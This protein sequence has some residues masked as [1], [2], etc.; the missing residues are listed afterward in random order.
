MASQLDGWVYVDD[1]D[2]RI[3]FSDNWGVTRSVEQA[4][5]NTMHAVANLKGATA[6]FEFTGTAVSV[7][8]AVGDVADYGW[9][10][11]SYAIDGKVY[12]TYNFVT[13]AGFSNVTQLRYQVP[14]FTVQDLPAGD[15]TLVITNLNGT[16][17]NTYWLDYIRFL[18]FDNSTSITPTSTPSGTGGSTSQS[19]QASTSITNSPSIP[20]SPGTSTSQNPDVGAPDSS[21]GSQS[22]GAVI[23]GAIG[24]VVVVAV[25]A[26]VAMF[27][28]LRYRLRAQARSE[29]GHLMGSGG[30]RTALSPEVYQ[31]P[32]SS[33]SAMRFVGHVPAL[34]N[35]SEPYQEAPHNSASASPP[36]SHTPTSDIIRSPEVRKPR[37]NNNSP[38]QYTSSPGA[39]YA[40]VGARTSAGPSSPTGAQ[41]SDRE[42]SAYE[43]SSSSHPRSSRRPRFLA[44]TSI[45]GSSIP[46]PYSPAESP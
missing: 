26:I 15:H 7:Y 40:D 28:Y 3:Q 29:G 4:Y 31:T 43:G 12:E 32:G 11:S 8:G 10:S 36:S 16:S 19:P 34:A 6:T 46:P 14:Y 44:G 21:S 45:S 18:P 27:L 24:G 25:A 33:S 23:G 38:S 13:A 1:D 2:Y 35:L 9:P 42:H 17:P 41:T 5:D 30:S 22:N 37:I 39:M 20:T